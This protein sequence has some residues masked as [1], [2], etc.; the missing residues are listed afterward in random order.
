[1]LQIGQEVT[2]CGGKPATVLAFSKTCVLLFTAQG[3]PKYIVGHW[4]D[5]DGSRVV[6]GSGHYY[7][8][9]SDHT[10][11][12]EA[13]LNCFRKLNEEDEQNG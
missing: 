9:F 8:V 1:M 7:M 2:C 10:E 6:W 5:V 12:M 13:A 11:A 4:Y 3:Y